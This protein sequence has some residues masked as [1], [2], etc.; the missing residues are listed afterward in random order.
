MIK[1]IKYNGYTAVPSDY[2]CQDGD[3]AAS[4]NIVPEDGQ[5]KIINQP[6]VIMT[7]PS[8]SQ[9]VLFIHE[10]T[11][12]KHY[13][14]YDESTSKILWLDGLSG[15]LVEIDYDFFDVTH[16]N[17]VGNTLLVFTK[18]DIHY[19]L[20]KD[21]E[22][23]YL[24]TH[25]PNIEISFGLVGHP[26]LFSVSGKDQSTFTVNFAENL[27]IW[28]SYTE[29]SEAN[30]TAVT[31]QVMAKVNRFIREQSID[32]GRFCFPF[33][34][35]YALR[36]YDG[37]LVCHSAPILMNPQ[38]LSA[39][40]VLWGGAKGEGE[41]FKAYGCDIMLV[42]C[43]LDYK[44]LRTGDYYKL[45]DWSDIVTGVEVFIS[46]PIYT[47]EQ[48]GKISS[49][50]DTDNFDSTFIGRIYHK[51]YH[52]G[53]AP[54][55][56]TSVTEDC[57]LGP[58][59][60]GQTSDY[61]NCYAEWTYQRLY[62]LYFS[63]DRTY[64]SHT[65]HMPELSDEKIGESLRS[66]S[67]FY[68]LR[69]LAPSDINET[70]RKVIAIDDDYLQSLVAREVM[71]DDY[72]TH[73]PLSATSSQGY[74]SRLNLSGV[75]RTLFNGFSCSSMFA[76]TDRFIATWQVEDAKVK[77]SPTTFAD[78]V[79]I[80]IYV[81]EGGKVHYVTSQGECGA[82]LS[83]TVQEK[84]PDTENEYRDVLVKRSSGCYIFYPNVNATHAV[85]SSIY[86]DSGS[87]YGGGSMVVELKPH[88]FL[89]GAYALIDYNMERKHNYS[90]D[91]VPQITTVP[92]G[93]INTV[94]CGS[95][96]YTSEVNNPFYFPVTGINTIGTGRIL[97]I[98]T[99]AKALSQGQFGQFPL[100]AFT[101]EGVWA[102]EVSSTGSYSARQPITRDVCINADGITQ[103]DSAV[104]FP[105]E[106]GIMLISGSQTQCISDTINSEYP[107]D[108]LSLPGFGKL[109]DMLEHNPTNDKCLPTL[110]F[111]EF[112]RQCRMIYDYVHQRVI[113]YAPGITYAYVFSLKS[114]MWGMTFSNIA[115]HLN[116]YPEALAITTDGK[117][118]N[119]AKTDGKMVNF[120]K[121]D[122]EEVNGLFLTRPLKLETPD[123][124][125]TMD[126]VIQRGH[127]RKG[128]VQSVLY[129]SRD[130]INWH[131]VWSSKDHF[132]RGFRGTPYKYFRIACVTSLS[133][134]ESIF[135]ASLQFN[136]RLTNQPR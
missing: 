73:D 131:L 1:D 34:V 85:I 20:W 80:G 124:L 67:Q 36:L 24:G 122:G 82:F 14:I 18:T 130:L 50:R 114:K 3:L 77:V 11:G 115:S 56:P 129:G 88:D 29:L 92:Y 93:E 60:Q 44:V 9:R 21:T 117:M 101:D 95:K 94:D 8:L 96:L 35:R 15:T 10:A 47:Y 66:C 26:R 133:E 123:V 17:A 49:L 79:R 135:G 28:G 112:L 61:L 106:R 42:A 51:N 86:G 62:A 2:E 23:K 116:S 78:V 125:K 13:I 102:L 121:T 38:T 12:Y 25:L 97:G 46:K 107:F 31:E 45:N 53:G 108:A 72:L 43:D 68:K 89:N 27:S 110:P 71:T 132:L 30:K 83:P 55:Y 74:N 63:S 120:A 91:L 98:A 75:K 57:V 128:H 39:P 113:V 119:F 32:K 16:C 58:M 109:H 90:A 19:L 70:Q 69:T 118:V 87:P 22:Y 41:Y 111:S 4:I 40:L 76:F 59:A 126:T 6:T 48:E 33:F 5:L 134:D 104:L 99:A 127:F 105:T 54:Q 136:P 81:K 100:Y 65:F 84:K 64:P 52:R 103:L 37:S 7:L